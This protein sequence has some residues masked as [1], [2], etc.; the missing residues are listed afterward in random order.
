[1]GKVITIGFF[2]LLFLA[3]GKESIPFYTGGNGVFFRQEETVG[4]LDF[5]EYREGVREI[6][7]SVPLYLLGEAL[8]EPMALT[9]EATA[10]AT[11][12]PGR[13]YELTDALV[14]RTDSLTDTLYL[15]IYRSAAMEK[16]TLRLILKL[17][18]RLEW[19]GGEN[20]TYTD[21]LFIFIS[22]VLAEPSFWASRINYYGPVSANK[23]RVLLRLFPEEVAIEV[24]YGSLNNSAITWSGRF[25]AYLKEKESAGTPVL[26][27]DG[28]LMK[29]GPLTQ[30]E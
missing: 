30:Q 12:I 11:A 19:K 27:E 8:K 21:S 17:R 6:T 16:D 15:K 2:A 22:D 7:F 1:M 23:L 18:Q 29:A 4:F 13:D 25:A 28:T 14:F 5:S 24:A 10:G 9:L 26:E 20:E 3:C